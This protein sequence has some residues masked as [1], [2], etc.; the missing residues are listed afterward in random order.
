MPRLNADGD[1]NPYLW[2]DI[3]KTK[4]YNYFYNKKI[5]AYGDFFDLLDE[6]WWDLVSNVWYPDKIDYSRS[7]P[8]LID[9]IYKFLKFSHPDILKNKSLILQSFYHIEKEMKKLEETDNSFFEKFVNSSVTDKEFNSIFN[10]WSKTS[11]SFAL[12]KIVKDFY[13]EKNNK[14]EK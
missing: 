4:T 8:E 11:L 1:T 10:T 3:K 13:V 2:G 14:Y 5:M 6:Y 12:D 9:K 7:Y